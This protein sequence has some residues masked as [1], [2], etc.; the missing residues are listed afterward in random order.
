MIVVNKELGDAIK[1]MEDMEQVK[2]VEEYSNMIYFDGTV[3]EIPYTYYEL[4]V[5]YRVKS[6]G[7]KIK[8]I[9]K[10]RDL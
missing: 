7:N 4:Y 5:K 8:F 2:V 3:D 1:G 10:H 9:V 6:K